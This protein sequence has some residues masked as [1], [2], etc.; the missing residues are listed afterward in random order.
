MAGR[1]LNANG[2]VPAHDAVVVVPS[3]VTVIPTTRALYV[4]ATGNVAVRMADRSP[5]TPGGSGGTVVF[6]S[7]PAGFILPI[8]VDLVL[9]T[10]TTA[11]SILAL[12]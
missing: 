3:D 1:T 6:A 11:S 9:S 10:G 8:Q 12:Y 7:V 2:T 5:T 4:G